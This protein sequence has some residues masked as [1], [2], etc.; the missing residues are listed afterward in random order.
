[1]ETR[2]ELLLRKI[3]EYC[4][5]IENNLKRYD[6]SKE[7]FQADAMFMD[8]CCM[9]IVQ[10]GELVGQLSDSTKLRSPNVPW[11][12]IKDTRNFYVHA[13]GSIDPNAVWETLVGDIPVLK[14]TCKAIL[15]SLS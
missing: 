15:S 10:I 4:D 2:D 11:R 3:I 13:Y 7:A 12:A 5:R 1:M 9:C 6:H 14:T 8:A